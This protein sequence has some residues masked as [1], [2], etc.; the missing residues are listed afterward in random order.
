[1]SIDRSTLVLHALGI[2]AAMSSLPLV[3]S[4]AFAAGSLASSSAS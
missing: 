2:S 3:A 1:M 4:V